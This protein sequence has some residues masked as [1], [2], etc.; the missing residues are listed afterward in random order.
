M[1]TTSGIPISSGNCTGG[2][3]P[4]GVLPT[5]ANDHVETQ[6]GLVICRGDSGGAAYVLTARDELS[7]PRSIVGINAG[8]FPKQRISAITPF[9]GASAEF[10]HAWT[11]DKKV[12][13]CGIHSQAVNCR[14][15]FVP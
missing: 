8:Y 13:V 2:F 6:G 14:D 4:V 9:N 10:I 5:A 1:S 11:A 3:A 12:F 15:R 7:G